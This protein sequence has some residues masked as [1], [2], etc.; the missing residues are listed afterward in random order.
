MPDNSENERQE[1]DL[2]KPD[3]GQSL[4]SSNDKNDVT[5][6]EVSPAVFNKLPSDVKQQFSLFMSQNRIPPTNPLT[7]K[8]ESEHIT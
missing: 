6:E 3:P 7:K 8:I 1:S 5:E 4:E 2:K